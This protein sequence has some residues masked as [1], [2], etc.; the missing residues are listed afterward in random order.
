MTDH[1]PLVWLNRNVSSNPR[2]MRWALALQ[3]YNF[4]IVHRSE[5]DTKDTDEDNEDIQYQHW[6]DDEIYE[7]SMIMIMKFESFLKKLQL[8]DISF[9]KYFGTT[10]FCQCCRAGETIGKCLAEKFL[11][12]NKSPLRFLHQRIQAAMEEG[13]D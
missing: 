9:I 10:Q 11:E 5:E 12:K 8:A 1:N 6:I 3:P 7:T 13:L 4:R 2:L